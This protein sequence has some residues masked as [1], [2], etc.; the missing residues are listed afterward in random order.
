MDCLPYRFA[1]INDFQ[2][3]GL[4]QREETRVFY[5][6]TAIFLRARARIT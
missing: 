6:G 3:N 5:A 2:K 4:E 1:S